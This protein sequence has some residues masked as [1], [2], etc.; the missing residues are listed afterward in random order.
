[1]ETKS[2]RVSTSFRLQADLLSALK[3]QAKAANRSLNNYVEGLLISALGK[4]TETPN[5]DTLSAIEEAR[6]GHTKA[7]DMSSYEAFVNSIL[8]DDEED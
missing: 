8:N 1:M 5:A 2:I 4:S 7:V 3:E 6:N